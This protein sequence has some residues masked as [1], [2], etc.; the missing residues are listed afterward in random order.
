M[1]C[2]GNIIDSMYQPVQFGV[3]G[4]VEWYSIVCLQNHAI[5]PLGSHIFQTQ[6]FKVFFQFFLLI[7]SAFFQVTQMYY[8]YT[9]YHKCW[10]AIYVNAQMQLNNETIHAD[11]PH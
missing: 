3:D 4:V 11:I 6:T 10:H 8:F 5:D 9:N 7:K 2:G 1:Q